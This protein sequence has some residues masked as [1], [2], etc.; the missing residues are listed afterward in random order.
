MSFGELQPIFGRVVGEWSGSP[1]QSSPAP[2]FLYQVHG[3]GNDDSAL[4]IIATDFQSNTFQV[5]KSSQQLEDLRDDIGIGGSWSDFVDYVTASLRSG[6]VKL[7]MEGSSES[8]GATYAK[9]IAQKAKGMPRIS[10]SLGKLVHG[11]AGEAMAELSLE[12]YKE[13]KDVQSSLT[14]EQESKCQLTK[15]VAAEKEKNVTLQKQLD[16][17]LYSRKSQKI[18]DRENSD[19]TSNMVSQDSPDKHITEPSPRKGTN[20]VVPAFRRSKVRG[21]ILNDTEE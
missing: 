2:P 17:V 9:L 15:T 19:S 4:R 10:F 11:A 8:G 6:D 18:N 7:I 20:R 12:L 21:A 14:E 16:M 13:F 1:P 3:S 5:I